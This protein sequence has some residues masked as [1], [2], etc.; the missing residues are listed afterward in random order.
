MSTIVD[1]AQT[2][3][4]TSQR[5]SYDGYADESIAVG[6]C[7]DYLMAQER[8]RNG[9]LTPILTRRTRER[10]AQHCRTVAGE[11]HRRAR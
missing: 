9:D 8:K 3:H 7:A 1:L 5:L 11:K 10:I 4:A 6:A 2:L